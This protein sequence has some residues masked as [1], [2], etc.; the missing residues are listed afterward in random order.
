MSIP[1]KD[2]LFYLAYEK[3]NVDEKKLEAHLWSYRPQ[4]NLEHIKSTV[5]VG[6]ECKI[7]DTFLQFV[8]VYSLAITLY[9]IVLLLFAG[10]EPTSY[11]IH[12]RHCKTPTV[13]V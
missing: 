12:P 5:Q 3:V 13:Y 7:L 8:S 4:I 9:H 2:R 10:T 11:S 6:N 1:E